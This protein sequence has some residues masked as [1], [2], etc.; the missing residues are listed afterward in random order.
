MGDNLVTEKIEIDP[1]VV[2]SPLSAA[3]EFS[4]ELS[5]CI[6]RMNRE[7]K[8]ERGKRWDGPRILVAGLL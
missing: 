5:R 1:V 2:A 4:V 7:R 3:E 8:V 6:N